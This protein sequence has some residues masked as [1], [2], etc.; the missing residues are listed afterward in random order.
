[1]RTSRAAP[2]HPMLSSTG[3]DSPSLSSLLT[4]KGSEGRGVH[5]AT[6]KCHWDPAAA[7][8]NAL[9]AWPA[10]PVAAASGRSSRW[11]MLEM[12]QQREKGPGGVSVDRGP[13]GI[14]GIPEPAQATAS[15]SVGRDPEL[16]GATCSTRAGDPIRSHLACQEEPAPLGSGT[17]G[18]TPTPAERSSGMDRWS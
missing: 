13:K 8:Q 2:S 15:S 11:Q 17:L 4:V 3:W 5:R 1:M 6:S 16:P 18:F 9:A 7:T 12:L 14:A 10:K